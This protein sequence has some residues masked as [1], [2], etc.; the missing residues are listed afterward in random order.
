LL[1]ELPEE[2][3]VEGQPLLPGV[4]RAEEGRDRRTLVV[5]RAAASVLVAL[6]DE[7]EGRGV[8]VGTLGGLD[9]EVVVDGDR[10]VL[11]SAVEAAVNDR[12][13]LRLVE[14]RRRAEGREKRG[15]GLGG[16][17]HVALA[18]RVDGD[19]GNLD[20]VLEHLLVLA[21]LGTRVGP[22]LFAV[23]SGCHSSLLFGLLFLFGLRLPGGGAL[24]GGLLFRSCGGLRL[25][26]RLWLFGGGR[27]HPL[28]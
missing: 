1:L 8:P 18:L 6:A 28:F 16:L 2:V 20:D 22:K 26:W 15:G 21:A 19:R 12:M 13:T 11:R 3:D 7:V 17:P 27:G 24:S 10:W 4:P 14:L 9:V 25:G 23:E 5:G